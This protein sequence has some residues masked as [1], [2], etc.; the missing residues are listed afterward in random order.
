MASHIESAFW[1]GVWT[2]KLGKIQFLQ[3][4]SSTFG[5]HLQCNV[6]LNS[7]QTRAAEVPSEK[8]N[9]YALF[10]FRLFWN[11]EVFQKSTSFFTIEMD[12]EIVQKCII[13][14][15]WKH[16]SAFTNSSPYCHSFLFSAKTIC[17][18]YIFN[19]IIGVC[20]SWHFIIKSPIQERGKKPAN[21][22]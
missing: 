3:N 14:N 5:F 21:N 19:C 17:H 9:K 18:E 7:F 6:F 10:P 4:W 1:S 2:G 15:I 16:D 11:Y 8:L 12:T 13:Q 22:L 20:L